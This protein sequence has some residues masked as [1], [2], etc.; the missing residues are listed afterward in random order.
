VGDDRAARALAL[1]LDAWARGRM[2]TA[3]LHGAIA[4]PT[5]VDELVGA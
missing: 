1:A 4:D 5:R 3:D 2:S